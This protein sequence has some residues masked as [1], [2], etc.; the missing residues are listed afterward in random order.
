[1]SA[2][3]KTP[4]TDALRILM[5]QRSL[6]VEDLAGKCGLEAATLRNQIAANFTSRRLR[7]VVEGFLGASIWSGVED[8][9]FRQ[10]FTAQCGFDPFTLSVPG[11]R[12]KISALKIRGRSRSRKK[13]V[14]IEMLRSHFASQIQQSK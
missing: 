12:Q 14:L 10:K 5:I 9:E 8:F 11:L 4:Q 7:L 13:P 6:S 3:Q 2:S 1:M